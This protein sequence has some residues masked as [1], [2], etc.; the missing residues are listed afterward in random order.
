MTLSAS[1][2]A[3]YAGALFIL[4]L[5]PGPVWV[6]LLARA[7]SGGFHAAWPLAL[8]VVVGDVLWPLLAVLGVTFLSSFFEGLLAAMRWAGAGVFIFMGVMLIRHADR[9]LSSDSRLTK[10]GVWAGFA[11]GL[12]VILGNPKAIL[13]YMGILPGF[14]DLSA[15][16]ALD[17]AAICILSAAVPLAGNLMLAL[18]VGQVRRFLASP[19]AVQRTNTGA[20]LA[21]IGV[22]LAIGF[23]S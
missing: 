11:A 3:L 12:L 17:I 4:F 15:V 8:G 5:T 14:F 9:A 22:G 7:V 2:L 1:S 10:P 19:S 20:G 6:A 16:T 18:G 21:L 13:F 23:L